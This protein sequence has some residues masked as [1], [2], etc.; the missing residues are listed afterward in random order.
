MRAPRRGSVL[1]AAACVLLAACTERETILEGQRFGIDVPLAASEDA[2]TGAE[3]ALASED[4]P[5]RT[6]PAG[7]PA[8]Q[9]NADWPQTGGRADHATG[10][11]AL[12]AAPALVWSTSIGAAES[13]GQR[14]TA[15]PVIANGRVIAMDAASVVTA[16]S[17]DGASL[18]QTDVTAPGEPAGSIGGG[19]LA[20]AEGRVFVATAYGEVI[21]LDAATGSP[22]WRHRF[23]APVAGAPTL[24]AGL[25]LVQ[26][27]DGTASALDMGDGRL[28]WTAQGLP[29][30]AGVVAPGAPAVSGDVA[31]FGLSGAE[32]L[33][34]RLDDGTQIW[35]R[36]VA[37][38]R[39]GRPV[40]RLRDVTGA[41]VIIGGTVI[42]GASSGHSVALDLQSG[43]ERWNAP[44][45][46]LGPVLSAGGS[47][48]LVSDAGALVRLEAATGRTVWRVP[49]PGYTDD[50][51]RRRKGV[52]AHFGPLL[53]GGRLIVASSDGLIRLFAPESGAMV[54]EIALP[55]GA[56]APPA[57]AGGTL[58]VTSRDGRLHAFR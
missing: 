41:P 47:V 25:V 5:N 2:A 19:G 3:V 48:Y 11:L 4:A 20:I 40:A 18:W 10:H 31:V 55:S 16:T 45:G 9:R 43:A 14:I 52:H 21:A 30:T 58:Y 13:A 34:L 36:S 54:G 37:G 23:D 15:A 49:L 53:A 12:A 8:P 32:L 42:A 44:E 38:L 56:A 22:L 28:R 57:L 50:D 26:C 46:A 17:T 6:A 35:R 39:A 33:A 7:L 29:E 1:L 27:R 24:A 51:P